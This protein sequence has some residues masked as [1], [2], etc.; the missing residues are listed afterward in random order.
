MVSMNVR[1]AIFIEADYRHLLGDHEEQ[2]A[3]A[4]L[5]GTADRATRHIHQRIWRVRKGP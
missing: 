5:I 1:C 4:A 3:T 2:T